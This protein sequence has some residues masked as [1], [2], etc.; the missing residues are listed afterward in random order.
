LVYVKRV[1]LRGFKTFGRKISLSLDRGLTVITGPNGSGKSNILDSVKFALGELSPRELRGGTISDL[2]HKGGSEAH[3]P[4]SAY[5]AVQFDNRD[6]RIPIDSENVTISR[7][8]RRGGE[9]IYRVNGRRI[10]RKQLTDILLSADIQVAGHNIVPQHAIT[11]LAEVTPEERRTIIE[12]MIGIA[13]YDTKKQ[14]AQLQLQQAEVNLK[15]ASAR[16]DEVRQRVESLERERN[17]YLRYV[18]LKD[19][20]SQLQ[21]KIISHKITEVQAKINE[22]QA[23][24]Q[25]QQATL[26]ELKNKKEELREKRGKI[27]SERSKFEQTVVD[28]GS[29]DLFRVEREIG[30]LSAHVASLKTQ[31]SAAEAQIKSLERQ[32]NDLVK[33]HEEQ[34]RQ[35]ESNRSELRSLKAKRSHLIELIDR[36]NAEASASLERLNDLRSRLGEHSKEAEILE[37]RINALTKKIIRVT[38]QIKA[39]STKIE[40]LQSHI[41]THETRKSEYE[42]L[43]AGL[44]TRSSDLTLLRDEEAKRLEETHGRIEEYARLAREREEELAHAG[45]VLTKARATLV[46]VETQRDIADNLAAEDK[47]LELIEEMSR[48]GAVKGVHGRLNDLIKID[49]QHKHAIEAS[50]SGW[51]KA[52]IVDKL[53]TALFC[54]ESLKRTKLGRVKL[55]PLEN[56]AVSNPPKLPSKTDGI[57]GAMTDF[58]KAPEEIKGAIDYVFGDTVLA[59]SQRAAFLLSMDGIRAVATTGDLYEPGGGMEIGYYREPF[60]LG[61]L[62]PKTIDITNLRATVTS[63][64]RLIDRSQSDVEHLRKETARIGEERVTGENLVEAISKELA[65]MTTNLTR[66]ERIITQTTERLQR[67]LK[68][69]ETEEVTLAAVESARTEIQAKLSGFEKERASLRLK[70]KSAAVLEAEAVHSALM[71]EVSERHQQ[72]VE[73][74]SRITALESSLNT[75]L[76][77]FTQARIQQRELENLRQRTLDNLAVTR[78]ALD[79]AQQ[80]LKQLEANRTDLSG[81]LASVRARRGEFEKAIRE[82]ESELSRLTDQLDPLNSEIV[83]LNGKVKEHEIRIGFHQT[84]LRN[85]GYEHPMEVSPEQVENAQSALQILKKEI[86]HIGAVNQLAVTQYEDVKE[87]YK[88]LASRIYELE[89]E[90]LSILKFMNE[91][92][93]KKL[94]EFMRAFNQVAATFQEIFSKLT[95]G[96][97]G[98]LFLEKPDDP[99]NGGADVFLRFP[100]KT[101]MTIGSA[102]GGEKSVATV[103]F[104]LALHAIHPMPF[105]MMDEIDAHLDVV[106]SQRL[107]DLLRDRSKGSQFI[108]VTLKDVTI[109]RADKVHGVFIQDG[110]SQI[111]SL[112]LHEAKARGRV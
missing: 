54:V 102:S 15:V 100:G 50:A 56:V 25:A 22:L 19:E 60:D 29:D 91:L 97:T 52:L 26:A 73:L 89:N 57:L 30:D 96:G 44:R 71:K 88:H 32:V 80:Q 67:L 111:V 17:D 59:G 106:N 34:T 55:I 3:S 20:V 37:Q 39:S 27:E 63:L 13:V 23:Q 92:D 104:L 99:F 86:D 61:S 87:N 31:N 5:V 18:R 108:V 112:P 41:K 53:E 65:S 79:E 28:Q 107:A 95:S 98:R 46:E 36:K 49:E 51:M 11:R 48:S 82:A 10:S 93:Q 109:S 77:T 110:V 40:L 38:A 83:D 64:E 85:L 66:A 33:R 43:V 72:K 58:V 2:I 16:I 12:D 69:S 103:C 81:S 21:A 42:E 47:A 105:Y 24:V 76:P 62:T 9:G 7:E 45:Q 101:E 70:T 84:E 1:D 8:F 90:K 74:D 4:K 14:E 35:V 68:Q 78:K 6:R 75:I 94:N